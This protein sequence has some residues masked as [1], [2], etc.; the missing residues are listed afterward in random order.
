M[1]I[2]SQQEPELKVVICIRAHEEQ[3]ENL[4]T[5][6]AKHYSGIWEAKYK[7]FEIVQVF[8]EE[9]KSAKTIIGRPVPLEMLDHC[10]K[11]IEK[12]YRRYLYIVRPPIPPQTADYLVAIRKKKLIEANIALSQRQSR[13]VTSNWTTSWTVLASFAQHDNDVRSER[14]R[15]GPEP[16]LYQTAANHVPIGYL[17]DHGYA[18]KIRK[19]LIK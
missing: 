4:S 12:K 2:S 13:Q 19:R 9:G 8:R 16:P 18:T 17:N 14:T 10:R 1:N 5:A 3:A 11:K 6:S 15:N 7:G